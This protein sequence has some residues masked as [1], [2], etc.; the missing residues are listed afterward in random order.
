M[1]ESSNRG[2][3]VIGELVQT[4]RPDSDDASTTESAPRRCMQGGVTAS[5]WGVTARPGPLRTAAT[6]PEDR[7]GASAVRSDRSGSA[8]MGDVSGARCPYR[9]DPCDY[10]GGCASCAAPLGATVSTGQG[11]VWITYCATEPSIQRTMPD[12]PWVPITMRSVS[13]F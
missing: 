5:T 10:A 6:L 2:P 8:G 11:A 9:R 3:L 7:L 1:R 12:Q 13:C 4:E